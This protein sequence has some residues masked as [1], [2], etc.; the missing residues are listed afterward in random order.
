M[1]TFFRKSKVNRKKYDVKFLKHADKHEIERQNVGYRAF[2]AIRGTSPFF[3]QAKNKVMAMIKQLEA[4]NIF[5]TLSAA[6]MHWPELIKMQMRKEL[7][8]EVTD[9]EMK[10]INKSEIRK[11][12]SRNMVDTVTHFS[13]R[14]R[15]IYGA[16]QKPGFFGKYKVVDYFYRIEFQQRGAPH[17]HSLLWLED[18]NGNK[19]PRFDGSEESNKKNVVNS[20][21]RLLAVN[22]QIHPKLSTKR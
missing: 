4:P 20:L 13:N 15:A 22:Y 2:K 8:H 9:D 16:M 14:V 17:V 10:E 11:L 6:Q 5:L 21:M 7:R 1:T 19:A 18:E 3:Q 12:I